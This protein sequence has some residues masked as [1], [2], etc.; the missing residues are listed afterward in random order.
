[1]EEKHSN[2]RRVF[3]WNETFRCVEME[4]QI[5]SVRDFSVAV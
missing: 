4:S 3:Q 5:I 1:M 2:G